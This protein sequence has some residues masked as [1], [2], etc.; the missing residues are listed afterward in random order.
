MRVDYGEPPDLTEA[1]LGG[2]WSALLGAWV[3]DAVAAGVAEANAMVVSTV[4]AEG[5]PAA[6]TV[7]CK[8]LR[9]EGVVFYTNYE[10]DKARQ[11]AG[12][13]YAAVTFTWARIARQVRLRGPVST[14]SASDTAAYWR[15]RP[16]GSQLGTW[17]SAQSSPVESRAA[18][19]LAQTAVEERFAGV[20]SIPV[21]PFW[22]GYLVTAVEV[23]F[24]Q[25]RYARL[26]NRLR[27]TRAP[28]G[29][30][31]ITRLQP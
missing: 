7:L 22:G 17:A 14:V 29:R 15:T 3:E 20:E 24:W 6:R 26:H 13:P 5:L 31:T 27:T 23:E 9:P 12:V 10:S 25:G 8:E 21:P 2:G 4:D 1:D 11:L 19:D 30:W 28:D 18:L 16:R